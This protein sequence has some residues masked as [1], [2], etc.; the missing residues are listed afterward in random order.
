MLLGLECKLAGCWQEQGTLL[1]S[2]CSLYTGLLVSAAVH[3]CCDMNFACVILSS[4]A[5][6]LA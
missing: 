1:V 3:H 5:I 6:L 2:M 4:A